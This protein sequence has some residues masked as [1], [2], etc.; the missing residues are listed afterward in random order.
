MSN[1]KIEECG[2]T[3]SNDQLNKNPRS[4]DFFDRQ[5]F[6]S[7]RKDLVT[8]YDFQID[9]KSKTKV[10]DNYFKKISMKFFFF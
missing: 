3:I 6:S 9:E 8:S 4:I 7:H 5:N 1:E 2:S 10:K